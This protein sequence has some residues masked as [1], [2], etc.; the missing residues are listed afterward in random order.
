MPPCPTRLHLKHKF[1]DKL[2]RISRRQPQS[3]KPQAQ[4]PFE[5]GA[6]YDCI[7][8]MHMEQALLE[9]AGQEI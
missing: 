3:I 6:L 7:G 1:K 5:Y 2:L 4:S 9:V 8:H